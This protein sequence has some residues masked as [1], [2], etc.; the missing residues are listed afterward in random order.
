[1][2]QLYKSWFRRVTYHVDLY[3]SG[4]HLLIR[5]ASRLTSGRLLDVGFGRKPKVSQYIGIANK[6]TFTDYYNLHLNL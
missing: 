5:R 6:G 2:K 4:I 3:L 1:M